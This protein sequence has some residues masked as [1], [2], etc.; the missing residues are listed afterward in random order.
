MTVGRVRVAGRLEGLAFVPHREPVA[1]A[2]AALQ[3]DLVDS[4]RARLEVRCAAHC[5]T[6][7]LLSVELLAD[8]PTKLC[9]ERR[10][11][12][13]QLTTLMFAVLC[14]S[15]WRKTQRRWWRRP[16]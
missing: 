10:A 1:A 7:V 13:A 16:T 12:Q 11:G 2:V 6:A 3:A 9:K 14:C 4:L 8:S 15:R 5:M